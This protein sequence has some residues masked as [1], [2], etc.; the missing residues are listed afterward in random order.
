MG[1]SPLDFHEHICIGINFATK[2]N[3]CSLPPP[4][5]VRPVVIQV[6]QRKL[7]PVE[8]A[9]KSVGSSISNVEQAV[10]AFQ[11]QGDEKL[12]DYLDYLVLAEQRRTQEEE[13]KKSFAVYLED[14]AS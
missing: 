8:T 7:Q 5:F 6:E 9:L 14:H 2:R 11:E 12:A 1:V 4:E 10:G 13:W 3:R